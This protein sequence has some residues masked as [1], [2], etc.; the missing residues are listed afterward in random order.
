MS[1]FSTN[2]FMRILYVA[3]Q[4]DYGKPEQGFSF[5]HYNFYD[6]FQRTGHEIIYFDTLGLL[7]ELGK[8]RLNQ[9]LWEIAQSEQTELMF[10]VLFTDEL[11]PAVVRRISEET[12]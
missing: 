5:E 7:K 1:P 3:P 11:D 10:T 6:F 4:Y 2:K 8:D 12:D 9:R